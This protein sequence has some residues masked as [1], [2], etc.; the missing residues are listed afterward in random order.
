MFRRMYYKNKQATLAELFGTT[1]IEV[2][3]DALRVG[4]QTY[5]IVQDVIILFDPAHR[6]DPKTFAQ[7]IQF[8]F[9]EEWKTYSAVLPEHRAEFDRYFDLVDLNALRSAR[10]CDLGCGMG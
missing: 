6:T 2:R 7:D 10:V 9:G 1:D 5:P 8:T 3:E 4:A